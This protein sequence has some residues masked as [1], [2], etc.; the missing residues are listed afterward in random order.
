VEL[1]T[2]TGDWQASDCR[3][4]FHICKMWCQPLFCTAATPYNC[5][6]D[7]LPWHK[8]LQVLRIETCVAAACY[9]ISQYQLSINQLTLC[10]VAVIIAGA[11]HGHLHGRGAE[12]QPLHRHRPG[13]GVS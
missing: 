2:L 4:R 10:S 12:S 11:A 7:S 13:K 8:K 9:R 5:S 6:V 3:V 1:D